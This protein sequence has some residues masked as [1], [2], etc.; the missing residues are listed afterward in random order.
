MTGR[1]KQE[2]DVFLSVLVVFWVISLFLIGISLLFR[3]YTPVQ[4]SVQV[5]GSVQT[6]AMVMLIVASIAGCIYIA[7]L[8]HRNG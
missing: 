8:I 3:S 7:R 2:N 4:A 5:A 6:L 1:K